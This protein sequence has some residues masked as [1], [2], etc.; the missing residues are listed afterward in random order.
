MDPNT[1]KPVH[2]GRASHAVQQSSTGMA[3]VPTLLLLC[4][5]TSCSGTEKAVT[6]SEGGSCGGGGDG[7]GSCGKG[8][9]GGDSM[10]RYDVRPG[11]VTWVSL[12]DLR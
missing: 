2:C 4:I 3:C 12:P 10:R 7:G 8:G 5:S 11:R 9:A 6:H 1:T